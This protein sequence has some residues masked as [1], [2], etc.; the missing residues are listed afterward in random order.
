MRAMRGEWRGEAASMR[1]KFR[2]FDPIETGLL[3]HQDA[4]HIAGDDGRAE[5]HF[6]LY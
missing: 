1:C 3:R 2:D 5:A 4:D 6:E